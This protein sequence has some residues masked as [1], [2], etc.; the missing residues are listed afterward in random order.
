MIGIFFPTYLFDGLKLKRLF[1]VLALLVVGDVCC[2]GNIILAIPLTTNSEKVVSISVFYKGD[3][4]EGLVSNK[5]GEQLNIPEVSPGQ[6]FTIVISDKFEVVKQRIGSDGIRGIKI[7]EDAIAKCYGISLSIVCDKNG[8][9]TYRWNIEEEDLPLKTLP[10]NVV[11]INCNPSAVNILGHDENFDLPYL[12]EVDNGSEISLT[13]VLLL[14]T[15]FVN[16]EKL[17]VRD[18]FSDNLNL[19]GC[20]IRR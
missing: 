15:V 7:S 14:P 11:I 16:A 4:F 9:V 18:G 8:K 6:R 17:S 2:R 10:E 13:G 1:F 19:R 3:C 12:R 20:H 5:I